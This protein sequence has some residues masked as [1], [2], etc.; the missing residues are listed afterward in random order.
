MFSQSFIAVQSNETV[1]LPKR[2]W[3]QL[4]L[5]QQHSVLFQLSDCEQVSCFA[6]YSLPH[7]LHFCAFVGGFAVCDGP[8]AKCWSAVWCSWGQ[9]GC[10]G[11]HGE[12]TRVRSA[13]FRREVECCWLLGS[14]S[15][16]QQYVLNRCHWMEM[17][18]K[19]G[20]VLMGWWKSR[21][22]KLSGT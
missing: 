10:D 15:Q 4:R 7:F 1:E 19:Q 16:Y 18:I 2:A 6:V 11:P 17:Y 13:S 20:C 9:E 12:K 22:Q 8:Q 21:D 5:N 3:S 14:L